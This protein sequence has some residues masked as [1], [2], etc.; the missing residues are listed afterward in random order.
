[1][2]WRVTALFQLGMM[3]TL[4]AHDT[5]SLLQARELALDAGMLGQVAAID[6]VRADY[7]CGSTARPRP[8][9]LARASAELTRALRLPERAFSARAM[10]EMLDAVAEFAAGMGAPIGG[11]QARPTTSRR[12]M[13]AVPRS[14]R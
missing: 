4:R 14:S 10:L 11:P 1:M 13:A 12:R 3:P 7:T 2:P 6:Y 9:P 8:L 5:A